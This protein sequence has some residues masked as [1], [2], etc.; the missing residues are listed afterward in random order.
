MRRHPKYPRQGAPWSKAELK[1]LGKSPDSVLARRRGRTIKEVV[2]MREARRIG[3]P[4]PSRRWTANEI[5]LLGKLPDLEIARR[6][7]RSKSAI[8][9]FR[10]SLGIPAL[11]APLKL[12]MTRKERNS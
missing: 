5:Q 4:L 12:R 1:R 9:H 2:A 11:M 8:Q 6:T 7:R 10:A 3:L